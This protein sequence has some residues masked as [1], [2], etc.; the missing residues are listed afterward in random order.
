MAA[1]SRLEVGESTTVCAVTHDACDAEFMDLL[2]ADDEW[3]D[4]EFEALVSAGW[5]GD[6]PPRPASRQGAHWP[7]RPGYD[8]R[9]RPVRR[10]STVP[11]KPGVPVYGRGPPCLQV[12][13]L[14]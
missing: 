6:V 10:P 14:R 9:P 11:V 12:E 7:R 13:G 5:G 8:R 3:V 1:D 2:V 4:R